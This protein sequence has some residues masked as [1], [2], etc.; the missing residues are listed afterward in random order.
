M[1]I[2]VSET[3]VFHYTEKKKHEW[4]KYRK[5]QNQTENRNPYVTSNYIFENGIYEMLF[6]KQEEAANAPIEQTIW[7]EKK[8]CKVI[9]SHL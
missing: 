1:A 3:K 6:E 9:R 8:S 7:G 5:P 2:S 4:V